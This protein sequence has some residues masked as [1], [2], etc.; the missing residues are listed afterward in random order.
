LSEPEP[1]LIT[2]HL[3]RRMTW[4]GYVLRVEIY[5]LDD[6]PGWTLEVVNEE[7]TSIVWDDVFDTDRDANAAFRDTL[8]NEGITAFLDQS[9]VVPFRRPLH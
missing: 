4:E 2:S 6:R 1:N 7:G 3:S 8:A 5:R 9:N